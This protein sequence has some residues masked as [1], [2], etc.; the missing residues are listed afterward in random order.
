MPH[1]EDRI[2]RDEADAAPELGGQMQCRLARPDDRDMDGGARLVEA[3]ILE[4]A[5]HEAVEASAFGFERGIHR[6]D[7]TAELGQSPEIAVGRAHAIDFDFGAGS[8]DAVQI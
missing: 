7:R 2:D 1:F 8:G 4:M 6:L 3:R 5:H